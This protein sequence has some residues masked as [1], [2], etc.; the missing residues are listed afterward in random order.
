MSL[1]LIALLFSIIFNL[2][3]F[4]PAFIWKTDKLT[5]LSY[6]LTF[7]AIALFLMIKAPNS[8][9]HTLLATMTM[10][11][12]ARLG[13]F[14]FVRIFHQKKD[15]RFDGIRESFWGF[16]KFWL[17]QGASVWIILL[18]VIIFFTNTIKFTT[19]NTTILKVGF[20][21]WLMGLVIESIADIQKFIFNRNPENSGKWIATG[22]WSKSRHPNYLGEIMI[23]IG[24][25]IFVFPFLS[26]LQSIIAILSPIYIFILLRFFTGIP[27]LEKSANAKWGDNPDY[28][29]Y[30]AKSGI[31]MFKP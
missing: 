14:L 27:L 26:Q 2:I 11:W 21:I 25:Y 12:A 7:F 31:L 6:G 8:F 1:I 4:V 24:I 16:G 28:I 30:K 23:W 19:L 20:V 9:A 18:P 13:I 5:D 10:I 3:L 22:L 15:K 29:N 17:L